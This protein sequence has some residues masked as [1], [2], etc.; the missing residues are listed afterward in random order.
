MSCGVFTKVQFILEQ[1]LPRGL[2]VV[3]VLDISCGY[4]FYGWALKAHGDQGNPDEAKGFTGTPY[5]VGVEIN[6]K[7]AEHTRKHGIEDEIHVLGITQE[8]PGD[9]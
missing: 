5:I 6:P 3:K 8:S 1:R 2:D 9:K 7:R 4:G